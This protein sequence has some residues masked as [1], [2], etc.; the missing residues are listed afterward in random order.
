M[1]IEDET[2][3]I[4]RLDRRIE[5]LSKAAIERINQQPQYQRHLANL[6]CAK[7]IG[8]ASS[9]ALLAELRYA[10]LDVRL[11]QSGSSVNR[12]GRLS[13]AGN[14]R[15]IRAIQRRTPKNA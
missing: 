1:L 12:P 15:V 9:I 3:G 10:G 4:E 13:K 14:A 5:K 11:C 7:G 6:T 2:D 8:Q